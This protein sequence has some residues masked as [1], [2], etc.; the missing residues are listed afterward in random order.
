MINSTAQPRLHVLPK[1]IF[2]KVSWVLHVAYEMDIALIL[3]KFYHSG[4]PA[5]PSKTQMLPQTAANALVTHAQVE[6][7][8]VNSPVDLLYKITIVYT[9]EKV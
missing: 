1:R 3:E 4:T 9:F 5:C 2:S 8:K 7:F 6:I